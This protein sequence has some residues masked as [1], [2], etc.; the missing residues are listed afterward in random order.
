MDRATFDDFVAAQNRVWPAVEAELDAGAKTSHWMW[1]VFP[2]L[3]GLGRSDTA[4]F[5]ALASGA[6]AR[7]YLAHPVLGPRLRRAV[8]L[9]LTHEGRAPGTILG[10]IDAAKFRSCLTLFAAATDEPLFETALEAFYDGPDRTTLV[11][12]SG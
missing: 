5:F 10:G 1:F 3:A 8:E 4:R 2:Q 9:M 11:L 7:A 6:E 12:L